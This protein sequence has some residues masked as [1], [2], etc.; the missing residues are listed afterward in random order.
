[1]RWR[2]YKDWKAA[3]KKAQKTHPE[4]EGQDIARAAM[5]ALPQRQK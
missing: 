5:R 2:A 4:L 3:L 1:M